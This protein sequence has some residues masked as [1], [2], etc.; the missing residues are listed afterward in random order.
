MPE[1]SISEAQK[2]ELE[3]IRE[4]LEAAYVGEYGTLRTEDAI[5]YLLDTYTPPAES[6]GDR[7]A[8][9]I[10]GLTAINGVGE[11]TAKSLAIAGFRSV[12]DV[13]AA[14]PEALT[15]IKG[16]GD[17]QAVD[18]VV[19][20]TEAGEAGE[21]GTGKA[22]RREPDSE[23]TDDTELSDDPEEPDNPDD[24]EE[25]PEDTL[26]QA[27][28]LLDAHDGRWRESDGEEPYEVDLPDGATEA[29]R[30]KDDIRRLL[31]KHWK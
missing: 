23:G 13:A 2:A 11:A 25:S 10:E 1:L 28:S 18:I 15:E 4:E 27:M 26:Q 17:E 5:Q 21:A 24:R 22:E 16:I 9:D 29:V 20:A 8:A 19:A 14:D 6:G 12:G 3:A 30:T 7:S 31:F